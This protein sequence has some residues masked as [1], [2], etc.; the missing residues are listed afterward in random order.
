MPT[1]R[2][3]AAGAAVTA[4]AGIAATAV[5]RV[6]GKA[7]VAQDR[8]T[9][10]RLHRRSAVRRHPTRLA[11]CTRRSRWSTCTP[12]HCCGDA[13]CSSGRTRARSTCRASSRGTSRSRCSRSR[14]SRPAISTW[15]A[16]TTRTDDIVLVAIASAWP[17]A[18]WRSLLAR[19]LHQA[20]RAA[21][22]ERRAEGRFRLVRT[23]DDLRTARAIPADRARSHG[24]PAGDRGRACAR[25]RP[26]QRR[27][28]VRGR[29]PDD[30]PVALLR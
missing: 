27:R 8:A 19:A 7:A 14:R 9:P 6:G 3:I 29:L 28:A 2:R 21:D 13:T 11:R 30:E 10:V 24:R 5:A 25:R 15:T 22:V 18:T 4:V 12:I 23:K 26:G 1:A 20:G 17:S 16:T